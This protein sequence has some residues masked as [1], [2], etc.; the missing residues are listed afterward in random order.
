MVFILILTT[1]LSLV[2]FYSRDELTIL[3]TSGFSV[4]K[5]LTAIATTAFIIGLFT[6]TAFNLLAISFDK[7]T[8]QTNELISSRTGKLLDNIVD[9]YHRSDVKLVTKDTCDI[10]K[11]FEKYSSKGSKYL[12]KMSEIISGFWK[13]SKE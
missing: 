4:W 9:N 5:A 2:R 12:D 3:F 10:D 6:I 13:D 7:K 1:T 8:K 11:I